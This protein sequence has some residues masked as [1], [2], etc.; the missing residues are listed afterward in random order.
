MNEQ[1]TADPASTVARLESTSRKVLTPCGDGNMVWRVW[2]SGSPLILLHGGYG[3]WTHWLRNIE[4][5]QKTYC[6][7]APDLPGL[8]DSDKPPEP[9]GYES[10]ARI[11]ADGILRIFPESRPIPLVGFSFG[12]MVGTFAAAMLKD[13]LSSLTLVGTS[14][15]GPRPP[16]VD[17]G[18]RTPKMTPA[19]LAALQ[20]DNLAKFMFAD[21]RKIDEMA[22]HLQVENTG[23][24]RVKS[25]ALVRT[26]SL[27][28]P[29]SEVTA[30][31]NSIWGDR[32]RAAGDF[33]PERVTILRGI[34]PDAQIGLIPGA[35]HWV[36][37]EAAGEFNPMLLN[38]LATD[39]RP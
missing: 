33:L 22:V 13:R 30:R 37:Y 12:S 14:G 3:S 36:Q 29:L 27:L 5:L 8:G 24:A 16:P 19:E 17:L 34:Q 7:V 21:P 9:H 23:R 1:N 38:F 15:F 39:R 10:I 32:D 4:I 35:G 2:G 25:R 26:D 6:I 18:R 11:V 31:I 28:K 20:R